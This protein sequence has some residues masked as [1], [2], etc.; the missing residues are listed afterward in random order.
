MHVQDELSR[1]LHY[2]K[3]LKTTN[4]S[5]I[6]MYHRDPPESTQLSQIIPSGQPDYD[7][8]G[9]PITHLSALKQATGEAVYVD[10]MPRFENELYMA[11]V[12][13][14][15]AHAKI[16]NI[17]ITEA[18]D[19]EGVIDFVSAKD[20][21]RERNRI[22]GVI[23]DETV[24]AVDEVTCVGHIIGGIVA[25]DQP[26][27]Q[28]AAKAVKIEYED[29]QPCVITIQDAIKHKSFYH[30][31]TR[32]LKNGNLEQGLAEADHVLEGEMYL[33]G[34]EHFYLETHAAIA[35]P[36]LE[37]GEIEIFSSTQNPSE[38]QLLAAEVLGV[39][40]NR[41]VIR[42]KRMGG[43]FGGKETRGMLVAIPLAVAAQ[44]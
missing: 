19:M 9:R 14:S 10:D 2:V 24:F 32:N 35:L 5:A 15:K 13:S 12:M 7:L 42:T 23:H 33:G 30:D 39:P 16:I 1:K 22:G 44:K 25:I 17:D 29:I 26:T 40:Q 20:I 41:I 8:V 37:D 28:R 31:W 38:I 6:Q 43:G 34:Q 27:A 18:M 21:P 4:K 3:P 36:K 11:L